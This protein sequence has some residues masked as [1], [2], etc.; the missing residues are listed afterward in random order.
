LNNLLNKF[1]VLNMHRNGWDV[2][3]AVSYFCIKKHFK[4]VSLLTKNHNLALKHF[5]SSIGKNANCNTFLNY[6]HPTNIVC[7]Q[8]PL[9]CT[10][11][12]RH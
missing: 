5:L 8:Q 3:F 9:A 6:P 12:N 4:V 1:R 11:N 2:I 10:V 7:H